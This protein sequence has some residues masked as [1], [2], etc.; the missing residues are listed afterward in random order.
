MNL[1]CFIDLVSLFVK[2]YKLSLIGGRVFL[3]IEIDGGGYGSEI[4][5]IGIR[6]E[7]SRGGEGFIENGYFFLVGF[8]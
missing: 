6:N 8:I 5:W 2:F 1:N 4:F 3:V 7:V